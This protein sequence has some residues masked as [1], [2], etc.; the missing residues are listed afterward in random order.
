MQLSILKNILIRSTANNTDTAIW[1]LPGFSDSS[2]AFSSLHHTEFTNSNRIITPDLPGF[3]SS[4]LND[5]TCTIKA[6]VA[7]LLELIS[8][9]T[10]DVKIGFIGHS[11]GSIIAVEAASILGD[12]CIGVFSIEGNLT[13][14]DAYF[15]GQAVNFEQPQEFKK[16][17]ADKIW[18]KG[19]ND[20]IF[21]NYFCGL[22][23]ADP[24]AMWR[25]GKDVKQYSQGDQPGRKVME[26]HCPFLYLWCLDNTP[27]ASQNFLS[28][29]KINNIEVTGTSH[30]PM[31]DAP[32]LT[33]KHLS[34]FFSKNDALRK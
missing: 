15:S 11:V 7:T 10:P 17:F 1:C 13:E 23:Q 25:F 5:H 30:W 29:N 34:K 33:G 8:E 24:T 28:K 3:G 4:P 26:L 19:K 27:V 14:E 16:L 32:E 20:E 12:R 18:I 2:A 6:Y 31:I 22:N 9:L 21:R